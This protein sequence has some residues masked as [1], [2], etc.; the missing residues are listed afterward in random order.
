MRKK[1]EYK[2]ERMA[3]AS[4]RDGWVVHKYLIQKILI[5]KLLHFSKEAEQNK[6]SS[7]GDFF[8]IGYAVVTNC[9]LR[10]PQ[11][12]KQAQKHTAEYLKLLR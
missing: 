7:I 2:V 11:T 3:L 5:L 6:I 10:S 1:A 9:V 8:C 12:E 4:D